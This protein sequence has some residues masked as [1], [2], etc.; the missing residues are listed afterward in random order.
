MKALCKMLGHR[1]VFTHITL[2]RR[3]FCSRCGRGLR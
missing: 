2:P 3:T 1:W